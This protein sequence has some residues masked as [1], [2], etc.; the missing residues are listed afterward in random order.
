MSDKTVSDVL[1]FGCW[2]VAGHYMFGPFGSAESYYHPACRY[3]GEQSIHIDSTLAPRKCPRTGRTTFVGM[4]PTKEARD[5]ISYRDAEF[6]QGKF[7]LHH[8]D[9]GYTA[10]QWWDRNQGDTRGACNSTVLLHGKHDAAAMLEALRANF[11]TV[12]A[13]LERAGVK[14]EA[15]PFPG[16]A[17]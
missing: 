14:L 17:T 16:R 1:Y 13:N 10:I 7:L 4:A 11:P 8:L 9:N 3:G 12:L 15:V 2:N 6:P 5:R